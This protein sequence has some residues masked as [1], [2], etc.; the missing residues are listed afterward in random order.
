[1]LL[2]QIQSSV[3][4]STYSSRKVSDTLSYIAMNADTVFHVSTATNEIDTLK[5]NVILTQDSLVMFCNRAVVIDE[6]YAYAY[7][8]VVIIH[9]DTIQI[10][11]DS[12]RYNGATKIAELFGE[13]ILQDGDRRL[14][15]SLLIYDVDQKIARYNTGGT[16]IEKLDTIVSREGFYFQ[17]QKKVRL[18]GSVSYIDTS[19]L[20]LTDSILYLY[21]IDQLNLIAPTR[22][23]ED[24]I[25]TYC[26]AGIYQLKKNRGVLSKN[27]Q[28]LSGNQLITAQVLD[29]NGNEKTYQFLIDP[30]ITDSSGIATGDTITYY[31]LDELVEI[32]GNARYQSDQEVTIAPILRYNLKTESYETLGRSVVTSKKNVIE[33]DTISRLT[34]QTTFLKGGVSIRDIDNKVRIKS[35]QAL[36]KE[37]ITKLFSDIQQPLLNYHLTSDSLLLMADTL[38]SI[39]I[40]PDTDSSYQDLKAIRKVALKNGNTYGAAQHMVFN[41]VDSIIILTEYPVLWSD[42]TQLSG[43]TIK[44]YLKNNDVEQISL[45]GNAFIIAPD[46]SG[47]FNQIK[48]LTIDNF[49]ENKEIKKSNVRGNAE[50]FYMV[51]EG[52]E[53]KG[54]NRTKSDGMI[55]SFSDG[56]ISKVAMKGKPEHVMYEYNVQLDLEEYY[57]EGFHWRIEERPPTMRFSRLYNYYK[58]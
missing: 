30:M 18:K 52:N 20:L 5:G 21:D 45:L 29:I 56:E 12:M 53:Y 27:V 35:D 47:M 50:L 39:D 2:L 40:Y 9:H 7:E 22:I 49:V 57:L 24:S 37:A 17:K 1:M 10:Y 25:E 48:G 8:N 51:K 33:A 34:S 23:W 42:S 46:S 26:E 58:K 16:I 19:R 41:R 13:V 44:I 3:A 36:K 54:I 28:V 6:I 15:T 11:A 4:Q 43:D 55:F 38:I 14:N 31:Q 32:R